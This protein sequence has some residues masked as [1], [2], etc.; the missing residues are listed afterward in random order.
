ML[1]TRPRSRQVRR[2][3]ASPPRTTQPHVLSRSQCA[4]DRCTLASST[5][6]GAS[7][8][9]GSATC[10]RARTPTAWRLTDMARVVRGLVRRRILPCSFLRASAKRRTRDGSQQCRTVSAGAESG[11][12]LNWP[13]A[14]FHKL[15][16]LWCL[17]DTSHS[18]FRRSVN[19]GHRVAR[20]LVCS[21]RGLGGLD[22]RGF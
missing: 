15:D 11:R 10:H 19:S 4:V 7:S 22:S 14:T 2:P 9:R 21:R 13:V 5:K 17:K 20:E 18:A 12:G 16:L 3:L 6:I 1:R 8:S